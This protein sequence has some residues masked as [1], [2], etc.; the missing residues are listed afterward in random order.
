ML[1]PNN[2]T[3]FPFVRF[4]SIE[5]D[6]E[7]GSQLIANKCEIFINQLQ[8]LPQLNEANYICVRANIS[9]KRQKKRGDFRDRTQLLEHLRNKLLL[10]CGYRRW[11]KFRIGLGLN[12]DAFTNTIAS[13]LQIQQVCSNVAIHLVRPS[14]MHIHYEQ[15]PIETISNWLH[16]NQNTDYDGKEFV[17]QNHQGRVLEIATIFNAISNALEMLNHLKEVLFIVCDWALKLI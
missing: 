14:T 17:N 8:K 16:R 4:Y 5:L 15:L 2:L 11:F 7:S 1:T 13:I 9:R 12:T 3:E 10:I 6:Y